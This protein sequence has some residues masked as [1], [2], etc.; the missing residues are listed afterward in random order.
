[1]MFIFGV[2]VGGTVGLI[3]MAFCNAA[4]E[5]DKNIEE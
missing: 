3:T 2:M 4:K 1:M 5:A